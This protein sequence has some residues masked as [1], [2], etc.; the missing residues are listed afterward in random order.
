MEKKKKKERGKRLDVPSC[1][2]SGPSCTSAAHVSLA[3]CQGRL[4]QDGSSPNT[5]PTPS[6]S[7]PVAFVCM[8]ITAA[9]GSW[10]VVT[11]EMTLTVFLTAASSVDP[12]SLHISVSLKKFYWCPTQLYPLLPS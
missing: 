10:L 11:R 4:D 5:P 12:A 6:L 3:I 9:Q 1:L 7:L 8:Y 2:G